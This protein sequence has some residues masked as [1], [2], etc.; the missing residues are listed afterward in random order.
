MG[1]VK[2]IEAAGLGSL[3]THGGKG[4][5]S[6][7]LR[8]HV[9][10]GPAAVIGRPVS[11]RLSQAELDWVL[12]HLATRP[13]YRHVFRGVADKLDELEAIVSGDGTGVVQKTQGRL[14][15]LNA[16]SQVG[17]AIKAAHGK[18]VDGSVY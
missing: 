2:D 5:I 6:V 7:D 16:H 15:G 10:D 12:S 3:S 11:I 4:G 1:R 9:K 13:E 14:G 8:S 17:E 18:D